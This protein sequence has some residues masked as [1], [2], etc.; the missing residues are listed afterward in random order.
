ML[1]SHVDFSMTMD[2]VSG[3]CKN[4]SGNASASSRTTDHN[5]ALHTN[6]VWGIPVL[7]S[8]TDGV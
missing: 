3:G 1:R 8:R 6:A 7:L 4:C 2:T 5:V